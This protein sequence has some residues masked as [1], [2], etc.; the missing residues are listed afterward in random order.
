MVDGQSGILAVSPPWS[1]PHYQPSRRRLT[2]PNGATATTFSADEPERLRGPQHDAAWCDEIATWRYPE[3]LD[4][5]LLGLR[6]GS[7]ARLCVT[8]TP[9][10]RDFVRSIVNDPTTAITRANTYANREHLAPSFFDRITT[11]FEGT[12]LGRQK[13]E[14]ELV[15]IHDGAWFPAFSRAR[16]VTAEA[17]HHPAFPV[18]LAIDCGVSRHTAAVWFQVRGLDPERRRI[19]VFGDLH[20]EGPYARAAAEAIRARAEELPHRGSEATIRLDPAASA[21]T[22]IGPAAR[23]E[24]TQV[25]GTRTLDSWPTHRVLDGLDQLG[26]LIESDLLQIH[27]RCEPL[28]SALENYSRR[29]TSRGDWQDEPAD[30]QHPHEDLVDALRGGMRDRFPQGRIEQPTTLRRT[31]AASVL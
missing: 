10:A 5:L 12:T 2:W 4:N 16:H 25:F 27:P 6:L 23:A 8:T 24:Y 20:L 26:T 22:G 9:R 14:G 3:A 17:E 29:R 7:D 15:E 11:K 31:S 30:P 13:L 28:I 19:T 21:R 1:R 18:H